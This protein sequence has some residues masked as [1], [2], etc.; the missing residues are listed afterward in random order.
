M[1]EAEIG[2]LTVPDQ[3][4]TKCS[5]DPISKAKAGMHLLSQLL[6]GSIS[7]RITAQA[8]Q[9]KKQ[10]LISKVTRVKRLRAWLK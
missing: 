10:D 2:R 6:A 5:P 8:S 1:P 7:G 9:G 4:Q 3:P